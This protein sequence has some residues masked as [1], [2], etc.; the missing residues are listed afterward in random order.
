MGSGVLRYVELELVGVDGPVRESQLELHVSPNPADA[1]TVV[2]FS[3][4]KALHV[5]L[6]VLDSCGRE[7]ATLLSWQYEAGAHRF[8][9]NHRGLPSGIYFLQLRAGSHVAT[10]GAITVR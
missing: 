1:A 6:R 2:T 4:P 9:W 5:S 3:L 10:R 8:V 7:M